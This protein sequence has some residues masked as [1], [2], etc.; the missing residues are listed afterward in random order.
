[1]HIVGGLLGMF[2]LVA[3][4]SALGM[5]FII[6]IALEEMVFAV[7]LIVKGFDLSVVNSL[8]AKQDGSQLK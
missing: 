5:V 6:P 8:S 7:W 4:T 3:E 1:L 2:S